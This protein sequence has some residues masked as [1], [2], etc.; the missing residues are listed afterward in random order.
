[1]S[2]NNN[3]IEPIPES[4]EIY[5]SLPIKRQELGKFISG[6]LGQQ[7]SIE[8]DINVKFNIDHAWVV[9]LHEMINQRIHQQAHAHLTDFIAVIYFKDGLKRTITSFE[10][11]K[12]Y[13]ET[14]KQ[15]PVGLKIIWNYLIQFPAKNYPEKQ[16]ITFSAQIY[17]ENDR[18][19]KPPIN[20]T[21]SLIFDSI[22]VESEWSLL[23]YQIDHT[24]RTWGD[25]IEVIIS[26]QVNDVTRGNQFNDKLFNIARFI[27]ALMLV[28]FCLIYPIYSLNSKTVAVINEGMK[29]YWEINNNVSP[30]IDIVNKKLDSIAKMTESYGNERGGSYDV[31]WIFASVPLTLLLLRLTKKS[32]YSFLVF[33]KEAEKYREKMLKKELQSTWILV[34]SFVLSALAGIVGN[35]GYAWIIK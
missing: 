13:S 2:D 22:S 17:T 33:S 32:T 34:V 28:T 29:T 12:C 18:K 3:A 4:E 27:L 19:V 30:P 15:I 25:D 6:L 26:N 9:N 20:R 23:N 5:L 11:F 10:A 7:Q 31:L 1:M 16:Q 8:R 24:E 35:Y 14:K 21:Y